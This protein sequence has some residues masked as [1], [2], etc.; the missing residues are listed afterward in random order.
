M[1][2]LFSPR[3]SRKFKIELSHIYIHKII[4][5]IFHSYLFFVDQ[6]GKEEKIDARTSDAVALAIRYEVPIFTNEKVIKANSSDKISDEK[7]KKNNKS[8]SKPKSK[9][10][11]NFSINQL[12]DKLKKVLLLENYEEAVIIRDE[13]EKRKK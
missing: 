9:D 11:S 10:Y 7:I 8:K 6:N 12:K 2:F 5:G 13:I 1:S 4:N 3:F